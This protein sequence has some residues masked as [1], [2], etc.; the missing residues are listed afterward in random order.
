MSL[1][2]ALK[3]IGLAIVDIDFAE[4][5]IELSVKSP[6]GD[7]LSKVVSLPWYKADKETHLD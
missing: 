3:N 4:E 2:S 5:G 7:L 6:N 1:K